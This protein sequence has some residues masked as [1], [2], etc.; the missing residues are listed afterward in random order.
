M[1]WVRQGCV[2][3]LCVMLA[4][5]PSVGWAFSPVNLNQGYPTRLDDA[6]AVPKGTWVLQSALRGDVFDTP[7]G[8][9]RGRLRS[10]HDLRL[11]VGERTELTLGGTGLHG[12]KDPGTLDNPSSL[13]VGV[14]TQV[15]RPSED[16][17]T[18]PAIGVR[19]T[20]GIPLM[21]ERSN[22]SLQV[23]LLGSWKV[24]NEWFLSTNLW[25]GVVPEF[26]PGHWVSGRTHLW[27]VTTG[28]AKALSATS[29]LVMNINVNQDPLETGR[30]GGEGWVVSPELGY[31]VSIENNWHVAVGMSRD[32]MGSTGQAIVRT[33]VGVSYVF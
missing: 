12:P 18:L 33:T 30:S 7:S 19:V 27:G 17:S 20:A 32:F 26:E 16:Y 22:P 8:A 15:Y 4:G 14:M 5:G 24:R 10:T 9:E 25:Y 28:A 29:V 21:G 1:H 3:G 11:G 23:A 6:Y 2:M 13:N 31:I